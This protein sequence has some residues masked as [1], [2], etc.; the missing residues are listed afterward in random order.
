MPQKKHTQELMKIIYNNPKGTQRFFASEMNVSLGKV[1]Y[2]IKSLIE[3]KIIKRHKINNVNQYE[4]KLTSS[5]L[6]FRSKLFMQEISN[7]TKEQNLLRTE[8]ERLY[9]SL[10]DYDLNLQDVL[11]IVETNLNASK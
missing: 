4:Y 9:S 6:K 8:I 1:N 3:R 2:L 11:K 7:K 10:E 5:G